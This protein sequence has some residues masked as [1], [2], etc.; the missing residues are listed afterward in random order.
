MDIGIA[1]SSAARAETPDLVSSPLWRHGPYGDIGKAG[2]PSGA[3]FN[4][5]S[6][7]GSHLGLLRAAHEPKTPGRVGHRGEADL[8]A[9]RRQP[10]GEARD[11]ASALG[12]G[13][14]LRVE[15]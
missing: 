3:V 7:A 2:A 11:V 14:L 10:D 8:G 12:V 1:D 5:C 4:P 15:A 13:Q 9:L 6:A